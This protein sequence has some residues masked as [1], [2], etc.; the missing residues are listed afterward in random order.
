MKYKVG[1]K[2]RVVS[3]RTFNM[4]SYGEMDKYLGRVVTIVGFH[5]GGDYQIAEDRGEYYGGGWYWHDS[6][7]DGLVDENRSIHITSDGRTTHAILKD[8]KRII[9]RSKATCAPNDEFD[10]IKGAMLALSRL[11]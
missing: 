1:D 2:V 9:K 4:N 10:I 6:M 5:P 3:K 11:M 8:G 7:F